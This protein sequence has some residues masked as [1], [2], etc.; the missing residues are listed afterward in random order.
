MCRIFYTI[1]FIVTI[2]SDAFAKDKCIPVFFASDD[3]YAP[4]TATA[5]ASVLKNTKSCVDFYVLS[6][7]ISM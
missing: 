6:N 1:L 2:V 7:N 5:M 3:G 4:Y